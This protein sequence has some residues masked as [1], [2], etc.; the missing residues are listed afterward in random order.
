MFFIISKALLFL[1][2]PVNWVVALLVWGVS[3]KNPQA[4]GAYYKPPPVS[5]YY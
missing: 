5:A 2:Q 3:T 1:L 4:N